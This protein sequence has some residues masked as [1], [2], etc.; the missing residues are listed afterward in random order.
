MVPLRVCVSVLGAICCLAGV[1]E[2]E[3][4]AAPQHFSFADRTG[5]SY[6]IALRLDMDRCEIDT[7]DEIAVFDGALCVGAIVIN[8]DTALG[9][10]AWKDN[11][12]TP[13]VDG[14]QCSH[15]MVFRVWRHKVGVEEPW[16][17]EFEQGQIGLF[18]EGLLAAAR[19]DC[20]ATNVEEQPD[21]L[22]EKPALH[23]NFPNPFNSTTSIGLH[24]PVTQHVRLRIVNSLGQEV[25][26]LLDRMLPSG[27]HHVEWNGK[28]SSGKV[29]SSGVYFYQL[30]TASSSLTRR[31]LHLK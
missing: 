9:L 19:S 30:Q 11:L 31:M 13:E 6:L 20:I 22:P 27:E 1:S 3:C 24:L 14:Y 17:V 29:V 2:A 16:S 28:T 12:Q 23:Q 25:A 21:P 7:C 18:C 26:V 5:D 8:G 15:E 4:G 10:V